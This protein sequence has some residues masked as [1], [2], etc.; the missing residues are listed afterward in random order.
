VVAVTEVTYRPSTLGSSLSLFAGFLSLLGFALASLDATA[1]G[2][3]SLLL[4]AGGLYASSR[5]IVTLAGAGFL[6]A[7]LLAGARGAAPEALL[8]A[9]LGAVLAWDV[10]EF[11]VGV[12]EQLG[13]QA[14]TSRL[15]LVHAAG[16]LLVGVVTAG[17][18]YGVFLAAAGGRPAFAVV[19][20]LLG[21]V[22]LV[23]VLRRRPG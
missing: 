6:L 17:A 9:S 13:E 12:G 18:A 23:A 19:L 22:V 4:L 11:A 21:T 14:D 1:V 5:R 8:V 20:L 7:I 2:A 15:E 16:S 3:V 10:A